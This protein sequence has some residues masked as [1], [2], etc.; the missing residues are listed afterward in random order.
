MKEKRGKTSQ[1]ERTKGEWD[2]DVLRGKQNL[3]ESQRIEARML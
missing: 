3:M 2:E 1:L